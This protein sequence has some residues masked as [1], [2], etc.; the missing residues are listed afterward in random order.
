MKL[1]LKLLLLAVV[2]LGGVVLAR[3]MILGPED[4]E[5][6]GPVRVEVRSGAVERFAGSLRIPTI[7][8]GDPALFDP[9]P[10]E[11]FHA[12]LRE[13]FPLVHAALQVETIGG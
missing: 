2:G 5:V 4:E 3:A 9:V 6:P 1:V 12:Y 8:H 11:A 10:F 13:A 7:S